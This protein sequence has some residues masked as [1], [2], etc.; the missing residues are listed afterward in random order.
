MPPKACL[1]DMDGLLLDTETIYTK[2]TNI[3]LERYQK[4]SFPMEIKAQMMGRPSREACQI[5]LKWSQLD[6]SSDQYIQMQRE[7]QSELWKQTR[8][9]PGALELLHQCK[10]LDIP[11]A[12]ATS[13]DTHNFVKK[14]AHLGEMFQ[15]FE[16]N[17]VTGD[18]D[19]LLPGRGKPN[20]DIWF[21]ALKIINEK[22]RVKGQPEIEAKDCLVFEDSILGLES[23]RAADM[24]VIWVPD[25]SILPFFSL[26]PEQAA[27]KGVIKCSSLREIDLRKL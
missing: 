4:G 2:S 20:P 13:S 1:F 5:F 17:I 3:I 25:P 7:L 24:R 6:I 16:N 11:I 18:D 12:L 10:L 23:G 19:R 22:R 14:T 21:I 8:P 9:L 27:D 26:S 15:L